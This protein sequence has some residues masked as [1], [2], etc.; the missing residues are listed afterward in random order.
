MGCTSTNASDSSQYDFKDKAG[1]PAEQPISK[2][3]EIVKA[4]NAKSFFIINAP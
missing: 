1:A 2:I 4:I 3:E